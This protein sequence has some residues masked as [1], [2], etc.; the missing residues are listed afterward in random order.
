MAGGAMFIY[1][2]EE[3]QARVEAWKEALE[4]LIQVGM[5]PKC[6]KGI[7]IIGDFRK[8]KGYAQEGANGR[9]GG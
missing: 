8:Q 9:T 7:T 5:E 1:P 6:L 4:N 3:C 2:G